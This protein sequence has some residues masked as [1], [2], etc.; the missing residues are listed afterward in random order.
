MKKKVLLFILVCY[1][2]VANAQVWEHFRDISKY[3]KFTEKSYKIIKDFDIYSEQHEL[4]NK[5]YEISAFISSKFAYMYY[6]DDNSCIHNDY[7]VPYN[8]GWISVDDL[9]LE[10]SDIFLYLTKQCPNRVLF[11]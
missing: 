3:T 4:L 5:G 11:V 7:L 6:I 1:L 10:N 2:G 9:V 8:N